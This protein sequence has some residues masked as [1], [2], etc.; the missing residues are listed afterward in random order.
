M[1]YLS[2]KQAAN[3]LGVSINAV[4]RWVRIGML[5]VYR[6][7]SRVVRISR[8]D[9]EAFKRQESSCG[10]HAASIDTQK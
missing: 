9:W 1:E 6:V 5:P 10:G 7:T 3:D 8:D 2:Y 4:R